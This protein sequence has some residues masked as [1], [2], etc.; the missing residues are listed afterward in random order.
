M[1]STLGSSRPFPNCVEAVWK[2]ADSLRPPQR[3][4]GE[5]GAS[6]GDVLQ[7]QSLPRTRQPDGVL[8][9][10]VAESEA[11]L[12]GLRAARLD[13]CACQSLR[14]SAGGVSLLVV[15]DLDNLD[16]P[17]LGHRGDGGADEVDEHRN[18]G[19][20]IWHEGDG[21]ALCIRRQC[22]LREIAG[23]AN[24]QRL[25]GEAGQQRGEPDCGGDV[26][27][28]VAVWN[29]LAAADGDRR[30]S[31]LRHDELTEPSRRA[32]DRDPHQ[33]SPWIRAAVGA[34][35]GARGSRTSFSHSPI[36]AIAALT[37]TGLEDENR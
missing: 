37:G 18:A 8:T 16:L 34:S 22:R 9:D 4:D 23:R 31:R 17:L 13:H 15:M 6:G 1:A 5:H 30:S 26:D 11:V 32:V 27:D 10:G 29:R 36:A 28:H 12:L 3:A 19:G 2:I 35:P 33:T 7:L 14:G 24:D 20:E 25:T 21:S